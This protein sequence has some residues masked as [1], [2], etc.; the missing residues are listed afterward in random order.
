MLAMTARMTATT[1]QRGFSLVDVLVASVVFITGVAAILPLAVASVQGTRLARDMSMATWL[2]WQK[3][4][5]L[6]PFARDTP[7]R[8]ERVDER[9]RVDPT[10]IYVRRWRVEANGADALRLV[11]AVHHVSAPG[12]PVSLATIR[13][14]SKP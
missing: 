10:G 8:E 11:V 9:G 4:E 2:A 12:L 13:R 1:G 7:E 5:E 3:I 14:R 6:T